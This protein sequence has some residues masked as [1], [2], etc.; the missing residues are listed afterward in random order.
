MQGE[1]QCSFE[2]QNKEDD[3]VED[4][5]GQNCQETPSF[6]PLTVQQE[7]RQLEQADRKNR[8]E[9]ELCENN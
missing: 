5:I 2:K 9:L 4:N 1:L 8:D 3:I 6:R 7:E